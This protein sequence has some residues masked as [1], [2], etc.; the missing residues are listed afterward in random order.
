MV[1]VARGLPVREFR[2]YRGRKHYSGW[3]HAST[4]GRMVAYESR[5]E[6]ARILIADFARDV[7]EIAAQPFQLVG[8]DGT[9]VR[10][11]VP[12]L[13]LVHADGLV[14]VVDVKAP[15]LTRLL[16]SDLPVS[17]LRELEVRT[18]LPAG[19]LDQAVI[20]GDFPFSPRRQRRCRFCPQCLAER[21]TLAVARTGLDPGTVYPKLKRLERA[22]WVTSRLED[23]ATWMSRATPG[24]GPGK[25]R[26][27]YTLT[28]EGHRAARH[29]TQHRTAA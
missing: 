15:H 24:R 10:R 8:W 21:R 2:W 19:R 16:V 14:T 22:G 5:L 25:R 27:F 1:E 13:F 6:L 11:H 9:R 28:A 20:G 12:D 18:G 29:E 4:T 17:V 3:Y 26:T 7:T 23:D